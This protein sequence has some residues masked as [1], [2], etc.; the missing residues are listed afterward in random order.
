MRLHRRQE[1]APAADDSRRELAAARE[2]IRKLQQA[3][4]D[5]RAELDVWYD[6]GILLSPEDKMFFYARYQNVKD[7]E[8]AA[9]QMRI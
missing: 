9:E 3:L 4:E 7:Q 2:E 8:W 6:N 5:A 1:A